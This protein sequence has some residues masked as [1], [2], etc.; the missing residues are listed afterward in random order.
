M[1]A[2][3]IAKRQFAL[4]RMGSGARN[5]GGRWNSPGVAVIY[6][7]MTPEISAMEKLVHTGDLLP[8]DLVLVRIDLPSETGLYRHY[9]VDEVP[10]GW[11][12]L[13]GSA[14]A[15]DFGDAFVSAGNYLGIL[16]PSVLMPESS[17]VVLNPSHP[18]FSSVAMT[19][20]RS[21]EFDSRLRL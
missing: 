6:A 3:R 11:D 15:V 5:A 9:G 19:I 17:N 12:A 1:Q 13:P 20:V 2:W 18:E 8:T 21:F 14:A 7:G 10:A 16:V 4:D